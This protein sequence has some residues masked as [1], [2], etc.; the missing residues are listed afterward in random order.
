[1][2]YERLKGTAD[3]F[4]RLLTH[5]LFRGNSPWTLYPKVYWMANNAQA[6]TFDIF[7]VFCQIDS[8]I[9]RLT[10]DELM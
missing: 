9:L 6:P 7:V 8:P 5:F 4:D 10:A 2:V 1:M 3:V